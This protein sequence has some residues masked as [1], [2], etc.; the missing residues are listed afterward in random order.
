MSNFFA[1]AE[2]KT[3]KTN[4]SFQK[5]HLHQS[6]ITSVLLLIHMSLLRKYINPQTHSVKKPTLK[7]CINSVTITNFK[8]KYQQ[9][10]IQRLER[11]VQD[12]KAID[13]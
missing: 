7:D 2:M 6:I 10:A 4:V 8:S 13:M 9:H 1:S 3:K 11:N 12:K 5:P